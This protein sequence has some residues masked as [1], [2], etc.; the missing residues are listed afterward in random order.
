MQDY[1]S[2]IHPEMWISQSHTGKQ[3][4]ANCWSLRGI[5]EDGDT[6]SESET[7]L[8]KTPTRE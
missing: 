5:E 8:A 4:R 1:V 6:I 3:G 7:E 2:S